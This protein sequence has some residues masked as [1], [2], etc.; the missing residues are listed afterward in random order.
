M[1]KPSDLAGQF[2]ALAQA[3]L[4][5]L[6]KYRLTNLFGTRCYFERAAC[7]NPC[8]ACQA[9]PRSLVLHFVVTDGEIIRA[10]DGTGLLAYRFQGLEAVDKAL[11]P[12][13]ATPLETYHF[14]CAHR[15]RVLVPHRGFRD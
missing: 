15:A 2:E 11:L 14:L 5:D 6:H 8:G 7:R 10:T 12:Y 13:G 9:Q 3:Q 4:A 1:C